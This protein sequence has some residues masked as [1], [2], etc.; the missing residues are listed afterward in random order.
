MSAS[1][2][3][4]VLEAEVGGGWDIHFLAVEVYPPCWT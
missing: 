1:E 4:L 2:A 3:G